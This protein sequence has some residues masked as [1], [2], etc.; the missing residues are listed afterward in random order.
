MEDDFIRTY[1]TW[2]KDKLSTENYE[3]MVSIFING[4]MRNEWQKLLN[5]CKQ[6]LVLFLNLGDNDSILILEKLFIQ[7]LG[8]F[9]IEVRNYSV[10]MLNMI[11]DETTWQEKSAYKNENIQ[12]KK[13]NETLNI[14]LSIKES[15]YSNKS[16]VLIISSPCQNKDIKNLIIDRIPHHMT[17][18]L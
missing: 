9:D 13:I 4:E 2:Q 8:H 18:L 10:K 1:N 5:K 11:Y 12:I 15:D 14:E 16:I 3:D 17:Y 7:L 6:L